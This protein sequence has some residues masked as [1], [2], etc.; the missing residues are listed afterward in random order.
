MNK[1]SVAVPIIVFATAYGYD[2][3]EAKKSVEDDVYEFLERAVKNCKN[4]NI[5]DW[6]WSNESIDF[7]EKEEIEDPSDDIF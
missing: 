4:V 3:E 5:V 1:Y 2:E 6:D 7:Y